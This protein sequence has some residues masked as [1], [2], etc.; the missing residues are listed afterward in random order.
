M[1]TSL[2]DLPRPVGSR[3]PGGV[4][5]QVDKEVIRAVVHQF[6]SVVRQ[7]ADLG[8]VFAAHVDNWEEH[9]ATMR[10]FWASVLLGERSYSGNP[11]LKHL[12]VPELTPGHFRKWLELFSDAL[13]AHCAPADAEAWEAAARRMGFAM[14]SRLGFREIEDLLP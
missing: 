12:A 2:S 5:S 13:G 14:S 4:S 3:R 1:N 11:F 7:D 6:Y 10:R 9:L 8:P